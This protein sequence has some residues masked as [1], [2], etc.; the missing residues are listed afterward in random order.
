MGAVGFQEGFD[1]VGNKCAGVE[2]RKGPVEY[3]FVVHRV[4]E[5]LGVS[6]RGQRVEQPPLARVR[7]AGRRGGEI[8]EA[9]R[10]DVR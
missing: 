9:S 2:A 3:G 8:T 7:F 1:V 5:R 10:L 6:C 4:N